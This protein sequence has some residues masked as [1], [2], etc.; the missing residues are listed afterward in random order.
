MDEYRTPTPSPTR[1]SSPTTISFSNIQKRKSF[2]T[3]EVANKHPKVEDEFDVIGKNVAHK[4]RTFP[5][6]IK[7]VAEKLIN[8]IF[9]E[10]EMGNINKYTRLNLY[11]VAPVS[12]Q[13]KAQN[14]E[15]QYSP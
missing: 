2:E 1:S 3:L 14:E 9:F 13:C 10:C 11:Q 6:E 4:L 7:I 12:L 8:D 15:V 5:K